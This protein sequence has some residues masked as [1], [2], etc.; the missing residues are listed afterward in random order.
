[1]P[2]SGELGPPGLGRREVRRLCRQADAQNSLSLLR[3]STEPV[4]C[5]GASSS[6]AKLAPGAPSAAP[7]L[8]RRGR[9]GRSAGPGRLPRSSARP[10]GHCPGRRGPA[11]SRS[12]PGT[13]GRG[14]RRGRPPPRSWEIECEARAL[15]RFFFSPKVL[16]AVVAQSEAAKVGTW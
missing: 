6:P 9:G 2:S 11:A 10:S 13:S 14:E 12:I 8:S 3:E 16:S 1:M 7:E 5:H 4:T 15:P